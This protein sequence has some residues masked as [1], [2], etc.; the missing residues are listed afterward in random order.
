MRAGVVERRP[1]GIMGP[2]GATATRRGIGQ[3]RAGRPCSR[4]V[5]AGESPA[6]QGMIRVVFL[7][8]AVGDESREVATGVVEQRPYGVVELSGPQSRANGLRA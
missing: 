4:G 2:T 7:G 1:Y 6:L 5:H 8:G 3:T